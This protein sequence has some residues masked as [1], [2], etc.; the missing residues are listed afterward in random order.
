MGLIQEVQTLNIRQARKEQEEQK[1][2]EEIKRIQAQK[3][4]EKEQKQAEKE[5]KIALEN[6]LKGCFEKCFERDGIE[7]GYINLCLKSTRDEIIL[8]IGKNTEER[9]FINKNYERILKQ[10]KIIYENDQKAKNKILQMQLLEQ[11]KEQ[12]TQNRKAKLHTKLVSIFFIIVN[13][14]TII[15]FLLILGYFKIALPILNN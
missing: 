10:V 5:L 1:K 9:Y 14:I 4:L 2:L 13:P 3:Q 11:Q 7:K 6:D 8:N 15:L 12:Q